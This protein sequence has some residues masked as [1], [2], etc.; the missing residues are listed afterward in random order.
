MLPTDRPPLHQTSFT[1]VAFDFW[2]LVFGGYV[3]LG[4][5]MPSPLYLSLGLYHLGSFA[6]HT[7]SR[8][9]PRHLPFHGF[10][11]FRKRSTPCSGRS[12]KPVSHEQ[13]PIFLGATHPS[14]SGTCRNPGFLHE[15][16]AHTTVCTMDGYLVWRRASTPVIL[17]AL[18]GCK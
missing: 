2:P 11:P 8:P 7:H 10:R 9:R 5:Q 13:A 12:N 3:G 14:W 17:S 15:S 6:S 16:I 1:L 4:L 18:A